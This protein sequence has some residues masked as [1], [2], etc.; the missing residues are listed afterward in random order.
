MDNEQQ[1]TIT[2]RLKLLRNFYPYLCTLISRNN[3]TLPELQNMDPTAV[4]NLIANRR[5]IFPRQY[6]GKPVA[7]V[8]I[9]QM[10][11][12]ANWAPN[13]GQTEPWRFVV[14]T[15]NALLELA[16]FFQQVYKKSVSEENFNQA[17]YNKQR[18]SI[19]Q[20]S[21][22]IAIIMRRQETQKIPEI[23]EVC[24]VACAVQNMHL[25]ASAYNVGC[26]W[27]TGGPTYK[28]EGKAYF[29]LNEHDKLLGFMY[30]GN[31]DSERP[32][33]KRQ[34]IVDKISWKK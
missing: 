19:L 15:G 9:N 33:G 6:N 18:E 23:E 21:H 32:V 20:S 12:N 14:F 7:D 16:D 11:E 2:R 4:N 31:Y 34:P 13:H 10:L 27:S 3:L 1:E 28:T 24:A 22:V 29:G 8:I 25:T 30:V 17:K 5:S 26:Y